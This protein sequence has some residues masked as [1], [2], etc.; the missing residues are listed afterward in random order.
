MAAGDFAYWNGFQ[1]GALNLSLTGNSIMNPGA[2]GI[3]LFVDSG[4][5]S[6]LTLN[7]SNGSATTRL[8]GITLI[9]G[10]GAF[11]FGSASLATTTNVTLG[12]AGA[13]PNTLVSLLNN[14]G[15]TATIGANVFFNNSGGATHTIVLSG[16]SPWAF[17]AP[18][19]SHNG[20]Q[21]WLADQ[22]SGVVTYAGTTSGAAVV[23]V[24]ANT[25]GNSA[26]TFNI[27]P[28]AFL[29]MSGGST[30]GSPPGTLSMGMGSLGT[31]IVNQS[32]GTVVLTTAGWNL[33]LGEVG[34]SYGYYNM[35]GGS[36]FANEAEIGNNGY[37]Y[38][39]Q[40]GG[41]VTIANWM[42]F[43]RAGSGSTTT[44]G[45][46]NIS[47]GQLIYNG[48]NNFGQYFSNASA[49][50]FSMNVSGSGFVS[51]GGNT[52]GLGATNVGGVLNVNSGGT[53]QVSGI[54]YN[55]GNGGLN[56]N[57]GMLIASSATTVFIANNGALPTH[58]FA[59]GGTISNNGN[60]ITIPAALLAPTGSGVLSIAVTGS[61][62]SAPPAVMISGGGTGA[63]GV[64]TID[65]NGNLTGIT[66]TAPGFNYSSAPTLTLL[67]GG[68]TLTS[69]NVSMGTFASGA[70]TFQGGGITTLTNFNNY[71]GGTTVNGG[72]LALGAGGSTGAILGQ[73]NINSRA[74]VNL[75]AGDALGFGVG[76]SVTN[77]SITGGLLNNSNSASS[78]YITNYS[79]TG[80]SITSTAGGSFHFSTG[81][82]ITTNASNLTSVIAAPIAIRDSN[83]LTFNVA[84]GTTPTGVDL[85][86]TGVIAN[87]PFVADTVNSVTKTGA[88]VMVIGSVSD[89]YT[90]STTVA[91]GSLLLNSGSLLSTSGVSVSGGA[92]F[93]GSG[94][95]AAVT[96]ASGGTLQ[97]GF[98][99]AGGSLV[100]PSATYLGSGGMYLSAVG[101]NNTTTP[102]V[103][104]TGT[105]T[106]AGAVPIQIGSLTGA[107]TG[108]VY[109][110][111]NYG[112]I[113]GAGAGVF[114]LI[115]PLP[116]RGVGSLSFPAGQVDLTLSSIDFLHWS[117]SQ[118]TA[119]DTTSAN[120]TLN[121]NGGTTAYIDN[122]GDAVVFD[123]RAGA[124]GIVS[125][126]SPVHPSTVTFSNTATSYVLQGAGGI[127]GPTGLTFNGPGSLTINT[128]NGYAGPTLIH[129][130]LV[131][132]GSANA[133]G[134][135]TLL[136]DGG[137]LNLG[138]ALNNS[139]GTINGALLNSNA[140]AV[141]TNTVPF[142]IGA[143]GG[144]ISVTT[145]NQLY[146]HTANT[147]LGSGPLTL[148]GTGTIA[149]TGV[150]N[151][152][153]D[154]ANSYSGT[155]TVTNGGIFEYGANGALSSSAAFV[156]GNQ[157]E[158]TVPAGVAVANNI[159]VNG[160]NNSV[161]GF[162]QLG[163]G[164]SGTYS[165]VI[166][167]N[168]NAT[169]ALQNWYNAS[170]TT[171]LMVAQ[172]TGSGGL[173]INSGSGI[174]GI[175]ALGNTGN[176]YSGGTTV[177]NAIL[178]VGAVQN[179]GTAGGSTTVL[180]A[181][182]SLGTGTLTVNSGGAAQFGY[183]EA[184]TDLSTL[185]YP[186][187][188]NG[189][190]LWANDAYQHLAG[191]V[192][193]TAAGGTL[194]STYEG[195]AGSFGWNK[196]LFLDGIVTGSGNLTL[197]QAGTGGEVNG[198]GNGVGGTF[199]CSIVMFSNNANSYSG[200]ITVTGGSTGNNSYLGVNGSTALQFA[201]VNVVGNNS[202]GNQRFGSRP[203]LFLT[204]IGS[205]TLGALTGSGNVAL[206]GYN[207]VGAAVGTDSLSLIVGNNNSSTTYTGIM[208]G[209]GSLVK[210]G[211]GTF[212]LTGSNSYASGTTVNGG[213]LNINA[214][215]AL[216]A[217]PGSPL[218]NVIFSNNGT[219]QFGA[220]AITLSAS[221]GFAING[222]VTATL[223]TQG[224]SAT[225]N[226][227]IN[228]GSGSGAL[229]KV[230][231]G[232]LV[233]TGVNGYSGG[234]TINSGILNINSDSAL[235][236][237]I[238]PVTFSGNSTLQFG[239]SSVSL[240]ASRVITINNGVTATFDT[241]GNAAAAIGGSI[242]GQGALT[243]A[244]TGTLTLT[245]SS[246]YTGATSVNIGTLFVNGGAGGSLGATTVSVGGSGVLAAAGATN[247]AGNV[248]TTA[249]G[250][251]INLQNS[252]VD[253]LSIGGNL[254]LSSRTVL[255]L[256]LG[257]VA[258]SSDL[259]AAGA[260]S[261][262]ASN[263]INL[264]AISGVSPG[265]YTL[266]TCPSGGIVA[267][268]F[269][270]GTRP[271]IRGSYNFNQ[272]TSTALVLTIS[273][274][275]TPS[276]AYWTGSG[277][278]VAGDGQNNW[279]AGPNTT[280]NW[281]T[282]SA[283]LT[284]AGQ[285]P[286]TN[287]SVIFTAAN[288]VPSSG[289]TLTTQLD[290]NY[291]IQGL[292]FAVPVTTGQITST[293]INP[294]GHT[295]TLGSGGLNLD[296]ASLS[297][298][299][300]SGGSGSVA[301]LT[302]QNWANNNSSLSLTI[303]ANV[304]PVAAAGLTTL[305]FN[306]SGTGGV[307]LNGSL[308]DASGAP[309]ALV[310]NQAGV[311]QLNGS[312]TFTGGM[313]ISSGTVQLGNG[314]ALNA[315][316]PSAV[317]FGS[318]SFVVGDLRLNNN[319][320][321]VS[322]LNTDGTVV[323]IVENGGGSPVTLTVNSAGTSNFGGT[324]QNGG[325]GSLALTKAG[326]STFFMTG[327]NTYTG[328]TN[329]NA[330]VLNFAFGSLP[331]GGI[332]FGGG[333]LQWASGNTQDI[334]SGLAPIAAGQSAILDT[335]GNGV[336]FASALTGTGGLTLVGTS[337]L[338][339]LANNSYAGT[340]AV[341]GGT[342]QIGS[343]GNTGTPGGGNI[344]L[345]AG[346]TLA[347]D[348][349]DSYTLNNNVS[350]AGALYQIGSGT[351]TLS[352]TNSGL[353]PVVV[354][355][356]GALNIAASTGVAA[357]TVTVGA[358]TG[359]SNVL[360]ILPGSILSVA[361]AFPSVNA[362]AATGAS[363]TIN[364]TGGVLNTTS[365]LWLS[366]AS[367]GTGTMNMSGGVANIGSWLAVGRG[368][369]GG[370]LNVTGGSLN[371]ATNNLTLASFA[372]NS[373]TL[374]ISGG[375]ISAVNAIYVGE[376]GNGTMTVSGTGFVTA[377]SMFIGKNSGGVGS[378]TQT[379]GLVTMNGT[380][381]S[382]AN[383]VGTVVGSLAGSS[384]SLN[385]TGGT[386]NG[387]SPIMVWTGS[388][389]ITISQ[390]GA[391]PTL[392]NPGWI[393]LGQNSPAVGTL[394]LNS[395]TV[396]TQNDHLYIGWGA[397][398][399]GF[400]TMHGGSLTVNDIRTDSGTGVAYQDGGNATGNQWFRMGINAGAN[401]SYTLAGGTLSVNGAN[402]FVG[403]NG[404]GSLTIGGSNGG[405]MIASANT[406]ITVA[407]GAS[408]SGTM[409]LQSGGLLKAHSIAQGA[410]VAAFN[411]SGGTLEN[412]PASTLAV[413]MPVNL[414]GSGAVAI[415]NSET[416]TFGAA[417]AISGS[418]SLF[419]LGGGTLTLSGTNTY[420]GG[421]NVFGGTLVVTTPQ[422]IEDGT[423]L[424]VGTSGAFFAPVVPAPAVGGGAAS[425]G[426][427][428]VPEPGTL[429]LL[430]AGA[431][432]AV[433]AVRRRQITRR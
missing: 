19:Q 137:A 13:A 198:Y 74:A 121:S 362:G 106:T 317:T 61:G 303:N 80:G 369:D 412:T 3:T 393:T 295:L 86:N 380:A 51:L 18:I 52:V 219:L 99:T 2:P 174:G 366:S 78:S 267:A 7:S 363:G 236:N 145:A 207:E 1:A 39:N 417:A 360:N 176:S 234:T 293:V 254:S 201:T 300:I 122:P 37:G 213:V 302:G 211:S 21:I 392:V 241:N 269:I 296:S 229:R 181:T 414:S 260:V 53:L 314:G 298:A 378:Y 44:Y 216:G 136:V 331:L 356:A 193:V 418:G 165:G 382:A 357:G 123:D 401:G 395:G 235:G 115:T 373:G 320:V 73:L 230:G 247:I 166:N 38:Y 280:T 164:L 391:T 205:A 140:S 294:N 424:Y 410:G 429:A 419:K 252:T 258:G 432:A 423:N 251:I 30:N 315:A 220:N 323:A 118:S 355:G 404:T 126:S 83:N 297:S 113:A 87:G 387:S 374:N 223:D 276:T 345:S 383:G 255:D 385:I 12:G 93:G 413:T 194:G 36:L 347:F 243:V 159:T 148:T 365:E 158:I 208:S 76:T 310:F 390:T 67:G 55:T 188:L 103:N 394:T 222:G 248:T 403:E 397:G 42:L 231:T 354:T 98:S 381:F 200:V 341:N 333:T 268:D 253:T 27:V 147:L 262:A 154:Q 131:Q 17:N 180:T 299:T 125:I 160:G 338:T 277:S 292:T 428:A 371:I 94:G 282:D 119:W 400:F 91:S 396:V 139:S 157:G 407:N 196:G 46:A 318:G 307:A 361:G 10:A 120:W 306:G 49:L 278:R 322:S 321:A 353:G 179:Q 335:N 189:G 24:G 411:F 233:L 232:T 62:Y 82:G 327:A 406:F 210:T 65:G 77:V 54:K 56:L 101:S 270:L 4:Q 239:A 138:A 142:T 41:S 203:L 11:T 149:S 337:S 23:E 386:I 47:G 312:N 237:T 43:N 329:V 228:D 308:G 431:A 359:N 304:A 225:V 151:L 89:T 209:L 191:N 173:A 388:G 197:I 370:T 130:G 71:A 415:D 107:T 64:A 199:N 60:N 376:G 150:G 116:N 187:V 185:P 289:N 96:I 109:Q 316:N 182:A 155:A 244:G 224:F 184:N 134:F 202:G 336:S 90:G 426:V 68:G 319:S 384:G 379:G 398:T 245:G 425:A 163:G 288:A 75:T 281:S 170:V 114:S 330:G 58:I 100:L 332:A 402:A 32:G 215:A 177:N 420:T 349:S 8:N 178:L 5:V 112:S 227:A 273:A 33:E 221:R 153:V 171:G 240:N 175:L 290:A 242:T 256:D 192:N 146:F 328:G 350:G 26:S 309:L 169:V 31:G 367:G 22:G 264:A 389:T 108:T 272:S 217:V 408:S 15:N 6:P 271:S 313:T 284:D 156:L 111:I 16:T 305:T 57:G 183:H 283:G 50:G 124:N 286:G 167:L 128:S 324:L 85:F 287:T 45:I 59:G 48:G 325:G 266:L 206:T 339:L 351:L 144:T 70:M 84:A 69:Y 14:S 81:F 127:Y 110:L 430:A 63:T 261:L 372:G 152:R 72:T 190:A 35:T 246:N 368:G 265:N 40:S 141:I 79:L 135:G 326:S 28:G 168:A 66:I 172:V 9:A 129:G 409:N 133:L 343:G 427:T 212:T 257:S 162:E 275:A 421:T 352:G 204:G 274:N 346:G 285:V 195:Q 342:L 105:L 34:G 259:I 20:A 88:G 416:G 25:A 161:L 291:S 95:A 279:A 399:Q 340:T 238:G 311:T 226:G 117:G 263:T 104:V 97:G 186:I 344:V 364:M 249:S 433:V 29:A 132:T 348:R 92:A 102:N 250:A 358:N 143:N 422:G 405:T 214:D 301:L 334:S 375:T 377:T 218:T